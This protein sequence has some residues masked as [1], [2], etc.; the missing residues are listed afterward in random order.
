[1]ERKQTPIS[2]DQTVGVICAECSNNTFTPVF[3]IRKV[4]RFV[5]GQ[6]LDSLIPI[7]LRAGAKCGAISE[8]GQPEEVLAL[9]NKKIVTE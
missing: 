6:P 3:L 7:E 4:S 1:M 5:T 9:I 2:L 8:D